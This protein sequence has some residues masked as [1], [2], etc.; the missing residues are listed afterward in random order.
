MTRLVRAA[1]LQVGAR[2]ARDVL[3]GRPA[4][5]PLLRAGATVTEGYKQALARAGVGGVW[6]DDALGEGIESSPALDE[7]TRLAV[8]NALSGAFAEVPAALAEERPLPAESVHAL[9][10]TVGSIIDAVT[11]ADTATL[12]LASLAAV[13]AYT[14][15]HSIDVTVLGLLLADRLFR[16]HGRIDARGNR[17]HHEIDG[18]LRRLGFGLLLHD[19][20]KLAIDPRILNKPG[21][22][23]E[24]EVALVRRHP[25]L[26]VQ[27]LAD[28]GVSA[29]AMAVV[30]SHHER[31]D[32][33]GYPDGLTGPEIPQFA[34]IAAVADVFS[35]V[36]TRRPYHDAVPPHQ[37]LR[38][39]R[40][41]AGA[42]LDPEVVAILCD[43]VA[44]YPPGS[45]LTLADG[46]RAVVVRVPSDR[47]DRP[48]VRI[49]Q[50]AEGDP[51]DPLEVDLG[52]LPALAPAA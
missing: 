52:E 9:E 14:L 29:H 31:L 22:L 43:V 36:T 49:V 42:H 46:R 16:T 2:L 10:S 17:T 50:D 1:E 48:V 34:R 32:G 6:V 27:L 30:R 7:G 8:T 35:A 12:A 41:G 51:V 24:A 45:K 40:A 38:I 11:H 33:H 23:D 20:G 47:L 37:A 25:E 3:S 18:A 5:A 21:R 19:I 39:I 4:T 13:D 28:G 15:E 44:P 26:G